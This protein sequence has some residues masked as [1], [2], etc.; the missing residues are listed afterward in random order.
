MNM[1]PIRKKTV[2]AAC[3]LAF[4]FI[5]SISLH[6][7][8]KVEASTAAYKNVL[9]IHSYDENYRWTSDINKGILD[10]LT[11]SSLNIY[12][13]YMDLK[14]VKP[15][16]YYEEFMKFQKA[17]Y[18]GIS[19]D[20]IICSDNEAFDYMKGYGSQI[21]GSTPVVFCAVNDLDK[22]ML[23]GRSNYTGVFENTDYRDTIDS[24]KK[25]QPELRTIYVLSTDSDLSK[26]QRQ[27]VESLVPDY[28]GIDILFENNLEEGNLQK[29]KKHSYYD[30]AVLMLADPMIY[31]G[32]T[33]T[34]DSLSKEVI[35]GINLPVYVTY[36]FAMGNGF[37]GGKLVSGYNQ[38]TEAGVM[39]KRILSGTSVDQIP[40]LEESPNVYTYDY[41]SLKKYGIL[42]T[43]LPEGSVV[44]NKPFSFLETYRKE[45]TAV[46]V[47][48]AL[49]AILITMLIINIRKRK[50][51]EER[52]QFALEG[53]NDAVWELDIPG[54]RFIAS[55]KWKELTG[56]D[57]DIKVNLK[58]YLENIHPD[59]RRKVFRA[60]TELK[61]TKGSFVSEFRLRVLTGEYKW[62]QVR[63]KVLRLK[64]KS[65]KAY[66]YMEDISSR[67]KYEEE[68]RHL[69]YYDKLTG[70]MNR[71]AI[72][73]TLDE[74]LVEMKANDEKGAV[75]FVDLDDFKK[76][77]DTLGHDYGDN[78]LAAAAARLQKCSGTNS[79]V[80]RLSGDE[81]LVIKYGAKDAR[82]ISDLAYGLTEI[83]IKNFTI[84]G[85]QIYVTASVGVTLY[86]EDG[87]DSAS[88]L[89]N[90]DTA[91]YKAKESGKNKFKFYNINMDKDM[92]RKA[93][94]EKEL[95]EAMRENAMEVYYQPY[96]SFK[97]GEITGLEALLR[98]NS[99]KLGN[100][101][102]YEF[103]YIAEEKGLM[104]E[105]GRWILDT[106]CRQNRSWKEQGIGNVFTTVN[107][108]VIQINEPGFPGMVKEILEKNALLPEF[109]GIEIN[110]SVLRGEVRCNHKTLENL[111][112]EGIR[113]SLDDFGTGYSSLTYLGRIPLHSIKL[114]KSF[115]ELAS[116]SSKRVAL[117]QG[118]VELAHKMN[119]NVVAE[120]VSEQGQYDILK[121]VGCDEVQGFL[122]GRPMPA[123]EVQKLLK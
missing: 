66:G 30:T 20:V 107:I 19:F 83:F 101:P 119:L 117:I 10:S 84:S 74:K 33:V 23:A 88:L 9:V 114:D 72:M 104:L 55:G 15:D 71:T 24:I 100:V 85:K 64:D 122:T 109:L 65:I 21:F 111:A 89:K 35:E 1:K 103:I 18:G 29:L 93:E 4:I 80:G 121:K 98:W 45:A 40:V 17:K 79:F 14:R 28:E 86:P 34:L 41:K 44:I 105:L 123:K 11:A 56:Y 12:T 16:G 49:L 106:V 92:M 57:A 26:M 8:S 42:K 73:N 51:S 52:F 60:Y 112:S 47:I 81:F 118:I 53:T 97:T 67:K 108:S 70:L 62:L 2:T 36:D 22:S 68:I 13:D 96:F 25:M 77:N 59:D 91:M 5:F 7:M 6:H 46:M 78:L 75:Y 61:D 58:E 54:N 87:T 38:G 116:D 32:S 43:N 76:V 115:T 120:G 94:I 113:I 99:I 95:R 27:Y 102:P 69:A 48:F 90:A 82:E 3:F 31:N 50:Q 63:G 110:E 39:A 37:I